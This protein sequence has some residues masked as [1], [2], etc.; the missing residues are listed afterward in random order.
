MRINPSE[1]NDSQEDGEAPP[2]WAAL[3]DS[4]F[5]ALEYDTGLAVGAYPGSYGIVVLKTCE[6]GGADQHTPIPLQDVPAVIAALA[7]ALADA[8]RYE[9]QCDAELAAHQATGD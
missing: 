2:T 9:Q 8:A 6:D 4:G 3:R 5:V 7:T 1:P